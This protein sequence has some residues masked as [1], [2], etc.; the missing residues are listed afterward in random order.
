MSEKIEILGII[1]ARAGSTGL[2]GK[3]IRPLM[4]TPLIAHT[5]LEAK[6]SKY[7]S[8]IAVITDGDDIADVAREYGAEVPFKRPDMISGPQSHAFETYKYTIEWY[9]ENENYRP[10]IMCCMLCTTP[11]RTA[12]DIDNCLSSMIENGHDWG[13]TIN[14]IE[15]H[16]YRAMKIE[17]DRIRPLFDVDRSVMW[18]NRQELPEMYRFNGGVIAG[19]TKHIEDHEEYNIDNLNH[20]DI[21]VGYSKMPVNRAADIDTLED[22]DY[23][24]FKMSRSEVL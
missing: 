16:P 8:R 6:K 24:E 22:F 13:F 21:K 12:E 20:P 14:E 7:L 5:I 4:G 3:N 2:P 11:F 18:A 9:R 1:P 15:H 23:V 10:E 19:R 17:G